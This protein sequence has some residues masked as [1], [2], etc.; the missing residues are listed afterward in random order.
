MRTTLVCGILGAGKTTFIQNFLR[1]VSERTAVLVN[2]FGG[3]GIDG[4]LLSAEGIDT[5][6]LPSGCVCCTLRFDLIESIRD[7]RT[8]FHPEH[9]VIEPSGVASPS[10]VLEALSGLGI[11]RVTVVGLVDATEFIDLLESGMFGRFFEDQVT[12]SDLLLVNKT[13][14]ADPGVVEA[15]VKRLEQMNPGAVIERTVQAVIRGPLPDLQRAERPLPEHG[16]ALRVESIVITP[17]APVT[18]KGLRNVFKRLAQGKMGQIMR[19]KALLQTDRG[20]FRFDLA[21]NQTTATPFPGEPAGNRIV[22]IGQDLQEEAIRKL[23]E[24]MSR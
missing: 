23:F 4:E 19:A 6:E 1:D 21:S 17:R 11:D 24:T 2:D 8:R 12:Q 18:E 20:A 14:L 3:L 9:L 13:D 16:H 22:V 15:T 5:V 10:G 7:I